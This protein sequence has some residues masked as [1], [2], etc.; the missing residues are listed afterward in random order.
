MSDIG[1]HIQW[2][3]GTSDLM[4]GSIDAVVYRGKCSAHAAIKEHYGQEMKV[5]RWIV[6]VSH[7]S[8][9]YLVRLD[10]PDSSGFPY[11]LVDEH[12]VFLV[13]KHKYD[14]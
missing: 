2:T 13:T 3:Q 6:D 8:N 5:K 10:K 7:R 1:K 4:S 11:A 12:M 9:R 14:Q